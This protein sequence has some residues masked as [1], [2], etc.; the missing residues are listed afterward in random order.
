VLIAASEKDM[1]V[2]ILMV[3]PMG[4]IERGLAPEFTVHRL[5]PPG[6]RDEFLRR[7]GPRIRGIVAYSGSGVSVDGGLLANLPNAEIITNMGVG[8][9]TVDLEAARARAIIV[10]NAG[11][12]NADDV[13]EHAFGLILDVARAISAGDRYVRARRWVAD[14]RM[15][16]THRVTG[17]R[18]GIL[19]LGNIGLAVAKRAGGFDMPVSY[20]NRRPRADVTYRY[21]RDLVALARDVDVL[22]ATTPGGAET[23]HL[24]DRAVLDALGPEG[25]LVN[26]GR[27]SVVDEAA[28]IAALTEQRLAGAGLDVFENEPNL[29]QALLDLPNV[30]LQPH[31]G[32]ATYEGVAAAVDLVIRNLRA[33]FAGEKVLT[34]VA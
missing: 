7:T 6:D 18:L 14:G 12:V 10:T 9:E 19:G 3:A 1:P 24:I 31:Q 23:H 20:H 22:V 15:P 13:A 27:G 5:P 4:P 33:H 2:E 26:V 32:G 29:P 11:S 25:L 16:M 30:V 17:R 28:L 8:Y 21:V 34:P